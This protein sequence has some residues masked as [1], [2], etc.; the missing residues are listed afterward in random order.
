MNA[1]RTFGQKG[2][3]QPTP[4]SKSASGAQSFVTAKP[5]KV[6]GWQ[7]YAFW[8]IIVVSAFAVIGSVGTVLEDPEI[9]N[10]RI[11]EEARANHQRQQAAEANRVRREASSARSAPSERRELLP[12]QEA[13]AMCLALDRT[14]L[15][16]APCTYSG[17]NST[18]TMT[19]N[20]AA[21]EARSLCQQMV[22]HGRRNNLNLSGWRLEIRSPYSGNSS[23]AFC[24]FA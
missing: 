19:I 1:N 23:I 6:R 12:T 11:V 2:I 21:S 16:S 15:A 10:A 9:R 8:A 22:T 18:I 14:G 13:R 24:S 17:W 4:P 7:D 20:M 5:K 3:A